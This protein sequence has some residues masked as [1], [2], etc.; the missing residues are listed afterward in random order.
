[1]TES[2]VS[3]SGESVNAATRCHCGREVIPRDPDPWERRMD[4]YCDDCASNRCDC[5]PDECPVKYPLTGRA[6]E[7]RE[8][9]EHALLEMRDRFDLKRGGSV[10]LDALEDALKLTER[11]R[12]E[13]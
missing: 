8:C 6:N 5:Y 9:A 3:N 1:M 7:L 11:A 12:K 10:S 13:L 2:A 4:G